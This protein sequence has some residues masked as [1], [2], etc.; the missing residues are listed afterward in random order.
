MHASDPRLAS[1]SAGREVLRRTQEYLGSGQDFAIETTLS[2]NWTTNAIEQA[3]ARHFFVRLVYICLGNP[4]QC[5]QRVQERVTQGGHNV[6]NDDVRRRY[7]RSLSNVRQLAK[8]A[9]ET[10]IYDNS[11]PEPI[12]ILEVRSGTFVLQVSE[13]P[14]RAR[15]LLEGVRP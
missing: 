14:L 6:S 3:R 9:N 15:N 4:E 5:I 13:V 11:G 7:A 8:V 12:L 1:V 10:L 2:G